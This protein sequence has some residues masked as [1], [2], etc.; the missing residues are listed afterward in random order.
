[1]SESQKVSRRRGNKCG[2]GVEGNEK[3]Y[4][5]RIIRFLLGGQSIIGGQEV[6]SE[7]PR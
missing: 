1:M 6:G 4:Q 3:T 7:S 2:R 5:P